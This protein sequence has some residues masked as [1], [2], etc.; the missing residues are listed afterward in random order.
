MQPCLDQIAR[1]AAEHER[2]NRLQ[3]AMSCAKQAL[4]QD[5]SHPLASLVA[6]RCAR[7]T[8]ALDQA[9]SHLNNVDPDHRGSL[10]IHEW[11]QVLDKQGDYEMAYKAF[12][13]A[14]QARKTERPTVDRTL[15]P[16]FIAHT[17]NC[18]TEQWV[19]SW[20]P[21]P[22]SHRP[23]PLFMVGFNRSG[24]T[25]LDRML[26]SHPQVYVMEEVP[27][28]DQAREVLGGLYPH[29]L[30]DLDPAHLGAARDAYFAVVDAHIPA[31]FEGLVVDKLPLNTIALGLIH[32]LFPSAKTVFSL[33]HPADVVISNFMQN[34]TP[35]PITV[36]FDSL[37]G[38]AKLYAQVMGLGL[39]L[40]SMLPMD[41]L[42]VRYE[43]LVGDWEP[44]VRR[45]LDFAGLPWDDQIRG[46][47]GR[48]QKQGLIGTPSYAAVVEPVHQ[49]AVGRRHNYATAIASVGPVLKPF[50]D[51]FD[52]S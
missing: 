24:T 16:R 50:I 23:A 2:H 34:Y 17:D 41:V 10:H 33:R 19:Q 49:K 39:S 12:T 5:P 46:Y 6:A 8:G 21:L 27:A 37:E 1:S 22:Q 35:N 30:A 20:T 51:A 48:T 52:Y 36:H 25:L 44:Q 29:G 43:D 13:I 26:D 38:A 40:R 31:G 3:P 47:L 28:I 32:R 4:A 7:R 42:E 15:M 45:L 11:A 9:L 18:F 14:N